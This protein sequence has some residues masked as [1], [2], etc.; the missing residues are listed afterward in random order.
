MHPAAAFIKPKYFKTRAKEGVGVGGKAVARAEY[1]HVYIHVTRA[2]RITTR[3]QEAVLR[4]TKDPRKTS[5]FPFS[6]MPNG[7]LADRADEN[8]SGEFF[9][10]AGVK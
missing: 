4:T 8:L 5:S 1:I 3:N 6:Q 10:S 9:L 2:G 7:C